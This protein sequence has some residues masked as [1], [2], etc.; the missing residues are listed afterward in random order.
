[1]CDANSELRAAAEL[2]RR[3]AARCLAVRRHGRFAPD[4][5]PS[6]VDR[7]GYGGPLHGEPRDP[8]LFPPPPTGPARIR[9]PPAGG[10][11]EREPAPLERKVRRAGAP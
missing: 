2:D 1:M 6:R 4:H 10:E 9:Q 5:G 3:F 7:G 8:L 11:R